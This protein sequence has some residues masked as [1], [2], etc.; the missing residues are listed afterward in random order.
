MIMSP[1]IGRSVLLLIPLYRKRL[2]VHASNGGRNLLQA[3][4]DNEND[5]V[6]VQARGEQTSSAGV[7]A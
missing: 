1:H 4:H 7:H 3:R 5:V 6:H 2:V